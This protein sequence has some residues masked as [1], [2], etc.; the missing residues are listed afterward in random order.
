MIRKL[1]SPLLL[2]LAVSY[3]LTAQQ[4]SCKIVQEPK[5]LPAEACNFS[6]YGTSPNGRYIYGGSP[7]STAFCYDTERDTTSLFL[8]ETGA[9]KYMIYA[10][11][12]DGEIFVA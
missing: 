8:S 4:T 12:D 6:I 9:E 11:S 10:V 1:L 5:P 7:N 2:L 3:A